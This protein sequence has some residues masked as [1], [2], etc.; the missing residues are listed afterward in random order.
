[1]SFFFVFLARLLFPNVFLF[2]RRLVAP[3]NLNLIQQNDVYVS[4]EQTSKTNLALVL[5]FY[6]RVVKRVLE[7][8]ALLFYKLAS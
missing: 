3:L 2:L 4:L 7:V 1:M 8:L 6:C 5:Q